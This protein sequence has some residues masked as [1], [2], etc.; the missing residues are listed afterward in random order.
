MIG[1]MNHDLLRWGILSTGKI[2]R[3][4]ADHLRHS[5]TGKLHAVASRA[6]EPARAFA[7]EYGAAAAYGSYD[8]LLDDPDV[9]AVYISTPHPMHLAWAVRAAGAGKHILCEKP[10]AMNRAGA[11]Q[12][13]EA[14]RQAGVFLMEAFMYR[15]HPQTDAIRSI[16]REGRL[17]EVRAVES[18]FGFTPEY[19]PHDRLF[20]KALGGGCILDVGCYPI[21]FSRMVAGLAQ[22]KDFAEPEKLCGC[23]HMAPTGVDQHAVASMQF[24]G[25]LLAQLTASFTTNYGTRATI[26]GSEARLD[27]PTPWF[28]C[29]PEGLC[30]MRLTPFNGEPE[31]IRTGENKWIYATEA[32]TVARYLDKGQ[33]P[34]MSWE[35]S[36]GNASTLDLWQGP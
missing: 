22:G 17:G 24:S 5:R 26:Y 20:N 28:P 15:C 29:H 4:F 23:R 6:P 25:G 7:D 1:G 21:S 2:S 33:A 9:Q 31:T 14:A 36:L 34:H 27:I 19:N 3:A 35:D 10:L 18:V 8:E 16:I 12:I 11:G 13:V 32:D 30:E